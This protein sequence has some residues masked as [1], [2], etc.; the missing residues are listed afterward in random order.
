MTDYK[1]PIIKKGIMLIARSLGVAL[2]SII[3][4]I[5]VG[6]AISAQTQE[7]IKKR[8][9]FSAFTKKYELIDQLKKG[10]EFAKQNKA[11]LDNALPSVDNLTAM[12]DY[13][14]SAANKTGNIATTHFDTTIRTDE[15]EISE[16]SFSINNIGTFQ[17]LTDLLGE[18]ENAPYF[19]GIKNISLSFQDG[20]AGQTNAGLTGV[21]YIKNIND[22]N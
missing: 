1:L 22:E 11:K 16:I 14:N 5:F 18:I 2:A 9:E 6:R 3:V 17:S 4:L 10:D 13:I 19:M 7:I 8:G 12:S 15:L 20:I 21:A